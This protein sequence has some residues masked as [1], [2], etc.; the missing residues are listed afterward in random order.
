LSLRIVSGLWRG[1]RIFAPTADTTVR[2]TSDRTRQ[3][4]FNILMHGEPY[5]RDG[6]PLPRG[7]AVADIFA[8]SGAMGLEALSRGAA[9]C[10]FVDQAPPSLAAIRSNLRT[11]DAEDRAD[12]MA[13]DALRPGRAPFAANLVFLDPP[14]G[15]GLC[16]PA[17]EAL[18]AQGWMAGD[19]ICVAE[20]A[21][22]EDLSPPPGFIT[23]DERRYGKAKAIFL[24]FA[25]G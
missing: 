18:A 6:E 1:R 4:I 24:R 2:P 16:A 5:L 10:V 11:L 9:R 13:R 22:T 23:L 14:Y 20:L 8:G 25:G 12:V 15:K 19:A 21:I 7:A 17:L 3:A